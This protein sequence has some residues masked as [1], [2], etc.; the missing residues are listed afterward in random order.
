MPKQV[1][2]LV[3]LAMETVAVLV[4]RCM[5]RTGGNSLHSS[6]RYRGGTT[7]CHCSAYSSIHRRRR[8]HILDQCSDLGS[9]RGAFPL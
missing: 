8:C 1:C 2:S 9:W 6:K 5:I 4:T 3:A 7:S